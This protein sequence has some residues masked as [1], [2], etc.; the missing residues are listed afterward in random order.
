MSEGLVSL[1]GLRVVIAGN[2][3]IV[4]DVASASSEGDT[5]NEAVSE[6]GA[7]SL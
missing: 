3:P 6:R 7:G 2:F 1:E 4:G 5:G